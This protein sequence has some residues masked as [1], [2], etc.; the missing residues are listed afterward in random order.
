VIE[1]PDGSIGQSGFV[2]IVD[3]NQQVPARQSGSLAMTMSVA[4]DGRRPSRNGVA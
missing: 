4:L 2:E 3:V 1:E